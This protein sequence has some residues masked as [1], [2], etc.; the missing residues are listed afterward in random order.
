[1]VKAIPS[2]AD[3]RRMQRRARNREHD[4]AR[5]FGQPWRAW[6]KTARWARLRRYQLHAQPFCERCIERGE[7]TEATVAHHKRPHKGDADLFFDPANLA[8]SCAS[9]HDVDEQRIERGGSARKDFGV[10]GWA[11]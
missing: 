8:S 4:A 5:Q 1:M 7:T 2:A 11:K 3:Q 6:Y 10:D 9:C